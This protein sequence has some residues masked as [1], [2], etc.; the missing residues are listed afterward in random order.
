LDAHKRD[1]LERIKL[2]M[3][4]ALPEDWVHE[5]KFHEIAGLMT[6]IVETITFGREI[7]DEQERVTVPATAWDAVKTMLND[8]LGRTRL[9]WRFRVMGREVVTRRTYHVCPH[10]GGDWKDHIRYVSLPS[11][12]PHEHRV[13]E[14]IRYLLGQPLERHESELS[15]MYQLQHMFRNLR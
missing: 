3:A 10:I 4:A 15:R 14:H 11:Q 5:T 13:L 1:I 7:T 8:W 12:D 6:M 2:N 9:R